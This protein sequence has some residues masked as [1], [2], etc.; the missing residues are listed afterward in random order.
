MGQELQEI[1]ITEYEEIIGLHG[2]EHLI[3]VKRPQDVF[4]VYYSTSS[5]FISYDSLIRNKKMNSVM[6]TIANDNK[7]Y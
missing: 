2:L 1:Y 5:N 7:S 6:M 4:V 3:E